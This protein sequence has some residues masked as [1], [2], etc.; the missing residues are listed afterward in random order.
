MSMVIGV[1]GGSGSGKTTLARRLADALGPDRT[2]SLSFDS[3]YRE[4]SH[5]T[6]AERAQVNFDHPDSLDVHLLVDQLDA[7]RRGEA[8]GVPVYDFTTHTRSGEIELVEPTEFIVIEG[9]LLFSSEPVRDR[10]DQLIFRDCPADVRFQ[11]RLERDVLERDRTPESVAE[12]W[13][14]TV[15]P[16]HQVFVQPYARYADLVTHHGDDL[17]RVVD[18]IAAALRNGEALSDLSDRFGERPPATTPSQSG[19]PTN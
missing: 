11:R 15:E 3:Y 8:I 12:Q 19:R 5:L 7:L 2:T 17:D 16:M 14:A 1:C 4:L 9:I 10:L 13:A 6:E 18:T